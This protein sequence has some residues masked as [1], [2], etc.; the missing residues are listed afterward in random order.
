MEV[1]MN[2]VSYGQAEIDEV[3]ESLNS[4][5]VTMGEKVARF[6]EMFA[7]YHGAKYAVMVNSGSSANLVAVAALMETG[8]LARGD[9]VLVPAVTWSTGV[10]PVIQNGLIPVFV[11]ADEKTLCMDMEQAKGA[12][13]DKT[14]TMFLAHILGN[15]CDMDAAKDICERHGLGM[16]EDCCEALGTTFA[17]RK[18]G[19]FGDIS[20]FSFYFS[21][22]ITTI[23]GGM[24]LVDNEGMADVCRSLRSHGWTRG[25]RTEQKWK[26]ENQHI[27]PRF[28]FIMPGYNLRPT[29]LNAA[30]GIHQLPTLDQRNAQ[31][32]EVASVM[33]IGL[34]TVEE[35][36]LTEPQEGAGHTWFGFPVFVNTARSEFFDFMAEQGIG[37]RPIVAGNLVE[38]PFLEGVS[39]RR[40]GTLPV[41]RKVMAKGVYLPCHPGMT[42]EQIEHV[43]SSVK[44]FFSKQRAAE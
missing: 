20:T 28:L 2:E 4:G 26:D 37:T 23:E 16:I 24:L 7:A 34:R 38:Q 42:V 27:D 6:E 14:R 21:H 5:F 3:M 30:F 29:E 22:H 19:T 36:E 40:H 10:A 11:D 17:A 8:W 9:E 31:R 33:R 13:S 12:V 15:S 39:Y 41:A 35:I 25:L 43:I 18:V 32:A 44:G 1:T